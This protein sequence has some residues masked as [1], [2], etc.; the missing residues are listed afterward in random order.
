MI[1]LDSRPPLPAAHGF[2][3]YVSARWLP[4]LRA[5]YLM[6][7]GH[8]E[9]EDLVQQVLLQAYTSWHRVVAADDPDAYVY[10][11][12]VNRLS[13]S[14]RRRWRGETPFGDLTDMPQPSSNRDEVVDLRD[15]V[16]AL[17][18]DQRMILIMRFYEDRQESEI[19]RLLGIPVGT[20]KS[21]TSRALS[22][23]SEQLL[24]EP[25]GN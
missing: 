16:R 23:L 19:S 15:A 10:R 22:K 12:M 24:A 11:C 4:L 5:A 13:R 6:G 1:A 21:R 2:T 18:P 3:E 20:V 9:A 14:R 25:T 17:P 8:H 7:C